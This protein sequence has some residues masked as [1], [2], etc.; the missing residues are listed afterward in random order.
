MDGI[1]VWGALVR[2]AET[3]GLL[4]REDAINTR[5][6]IGSFGGN[7]RGLRFQNAQQMTAALGAS[8]N[9]FAIADIALVDSSEDVWTR[10]I[11][12]GVSQ[13][14][15][16]AV[17]AMNLRYCTRTGP[18]PITNFTGPDGETQYAMENYAA[19]ATYGV[20]TKVLYLKDAAALGLSASDFQGAANTMYDRAAT[21]FGRHA[22]PQTSYAVRVVGMKHLG[23]DG[24]PVFALGDKVRVIYR[25]VIQDASG[26]RLWREIDTYLYIMSY[27]RTWAS[28]TSDPR[29][30]RGRSGSSST[31]ASPGRA[32]RRRTTSGR[33]SSSS[34]RLRSARSRRWR[35]RC[36]GFPTNTPYSL[37]VKP[38]YSRS[39]TVTSDVTAPV[40][41]SH[42]TSYVVSRW[43]YAS[44]FD[45]FA[46]RVITASRSSPAVGA[47]PLSSPTTPNRLWSGALSETIR[48]RPDFTSGPK[49][50]PSSRHDFVCWPT[51]RA[52]QRGSLARKGSRASPPPGVN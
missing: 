27:R 29:P 46:L 36:L 8:D 37:W 41:G 50:D 17:P 39:V 20:R 6:D 34:R 4:L 45:G 24:T 3:F 51:W 44:I 35:R 19:Q 9:V 14:I 13:G 11:P 25:G 38:R 31:S 5:V 33:S 52:R 21:W 28:A 16:G 2:V 40:S 1:S 48:S 12:L 15:A 32:R 18:Y 10:V 7:P 42:V 22:S 26:N 30:T 47:K 43:R 49:D 23:S